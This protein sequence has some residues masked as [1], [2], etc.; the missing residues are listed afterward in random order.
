MRESDYLMDALHCF[1]TDVPNWCGWKTHDDDGN[2][3]E[4]LKRMTY[5]NV[6]I[7]DD[8]A[9]MPSKSDVETKIQELKDAETTKANNKTLAINKLKALGLSDDELTALR[10]K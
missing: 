10:L 2:K 5:D 3:I 6:K 1:N 7:I 9:T 8:K 4:A